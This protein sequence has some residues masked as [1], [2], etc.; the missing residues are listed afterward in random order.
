MFNPGATP[1]LF[2]SAWKLRVHSLHTL[3]KET[4]VQRSVRDI[5][6]VLSHEQPGVRW[7]YEQLVKGEL[8]LVGQP[9]VSLTHTSQVFYYECLLRHRGDGFKYNPFLILEQFDT[10][11]LLDHC[12]VST[13]IAMLEQAP[14]LSLGCNVSARSAHLDDDWWGILARLQQHPAIASRLTLELTET[15]KL[16]TERQAQDFVQAFRAAGA[17]V[18]IDDFG[19]G[20]GTIDCVRKLSAQLVKIDKGYLHRA[21][22]SAADAL[23]FQRLVALSG[24]LGEQVIVEGIETPDD[25]AIAQASGAANGQGFL[26]GRP[27]ALSVAS[28]VLLAHA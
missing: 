12:V 19:T 2:N 16:P 9:V 18:A 5:E 25:L 8:Y 7:V 14:A 27:A 13:V 24:C 1:R 6:K 26:F 15:A 4:G 10:V 22:A 3:N 20:F 23:L 11:R 21:R 17:K 28:V